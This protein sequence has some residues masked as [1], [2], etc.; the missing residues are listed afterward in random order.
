MC[1]AATRC[2]G[3]AGA[4]AQVVAGKH[5]D[6]FA[7]GPAAKA[8]PALCFSLLAPER[9]LD[10]EAESEATA[11]AWVAALTALTRRGEQ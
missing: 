4:C 5:T 7:R 8:P 2:M 6:V 1:V 11:A 10:L 9:T 3:A